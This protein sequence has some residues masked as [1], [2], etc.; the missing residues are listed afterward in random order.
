MMAVV[1]TARLAC[2][3]VLAPDAAWRRHRRAVGLTRSEYDAYLE[4]ADQAHLLH[5][6]RVNTLTEPLALSH[7]RQEGPFQPPQS[8]RYVVA[9]DPGQLKELI[10]I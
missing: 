2:I 7:L 5:L 3:E 9:S 8:F 6:R 4:G 10:A 1:G